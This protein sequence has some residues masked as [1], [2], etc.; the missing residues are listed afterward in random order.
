MQDHDADDLM[1]EA[2]LRG[3]GGKADRQYGGSETDCSRG[4]SSDSRCSAEEAER[5]APVVYVREVRIDTTRTYGGNGP[6]DLQIDS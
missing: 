5:E 4:R 2:A 1:R 6:D 3:G